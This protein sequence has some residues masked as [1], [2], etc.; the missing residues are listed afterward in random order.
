[1]PRSTAP[2]APSKTWY[3]LT[4]RWAVLT[5][6]LG[7]SACSPKPG[8][9]GAVTLD[10]GQVRMNELSASG[11]DDVWG[12]SGRGVFHFDGKQWALSGSPGSEHLAA[13]APNDVWG[14]GRGGSFAHFDG[15]RWETGHAEPVAKRYLDFY[16]VVAWPG[17]VWAT[18]G[19][20][21]YFR[22]DGKE[23]SQVLPPELAG[24]ELERMTAIGHDV[25][26][27]LMNRHGEAGHRSQLG[28]WDGKTWSLIDQPSGL[29]VRGTA[30]DDVWIVRT[31]PMHFDGKT[32][33]QTKLPLDGAVTYDLFPRGPN[34]A[35]AVGKN[36]LAMKWDG[37][38][39]SEIASG[40]RDDLFCVIGGAAGPVWAG[41]AIGRMLRFPK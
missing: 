22:Y 6:C 27:A 7:A 34:E 30:P 14:V 39:W 1:M 31:T 41:G 17:E 12:A 8:V 2:L 3:G 23:W 32:W 15:N 18:A 25:Y 21:G 16:S 9:W 36:G 33:T 37:K 11:P 28:H 35:Y 38:A 29:R 26:I 24:W 20:E 40:T 19:V 5:V 13:V 4:V 10:G